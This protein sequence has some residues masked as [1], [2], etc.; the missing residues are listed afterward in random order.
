ML[1]VEVIA[2]NRVQLAWRDLTAA[3]LQGETGSLDFTVPPALGL[4]AG[5]EAR[6]EFRFFHLG[7]A[8]LT[9]TAVD[10]QGM[11]DAKMRRPRRGCGGCSGGS[12]AAGPFC[13]CRRG[14]TGSKSAAT[15]GPAIG[16]PARAGGRN[17]RP[18]PLA[19]RPL[20]SWN[21]LLGLPPPGGVQLAWRDFTAAELCGGAASFDFEVPTELALE[22]GQDIVIG[23]RLAPFGQCR[24]DHKGR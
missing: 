22:G 15:P 14:T 16:R 1:G 4:G 3:E 5:D 19:R 9:I 21:S 11:P 17:H 6:L 7:N 2:M 18:A 8:D 13:S 23:L 12:M 20:W 10:L 24:S